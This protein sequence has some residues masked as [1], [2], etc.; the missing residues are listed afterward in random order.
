MFVTQVLGS[1]LGTLVGLVI[2]EIFHNV[3]GYTYNP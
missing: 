3:G 2:L 1:G